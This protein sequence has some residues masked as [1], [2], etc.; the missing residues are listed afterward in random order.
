[1]LKLFVAAVTLITDSEHLLD[2]SMQETR[3]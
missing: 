1:V 2:Y 3:Q